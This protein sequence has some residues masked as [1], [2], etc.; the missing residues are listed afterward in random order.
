M[1]MDAAVQGP[2][3]MDAAIVAVATTVTRI[4]SE[5]EGGYKSPEEY[6]RR[7]YEPIEWLS[8]HQRPS[9]TRQ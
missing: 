8:T 3:Q 1:Q 6:Q 9:E 5:T 7:L 2:E 4:G